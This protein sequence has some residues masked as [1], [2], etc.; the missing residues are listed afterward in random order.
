MNVG[1]RQAFSEKQR[2]YM[3]IIDPENTSITQVRSEFLA[4][5]CVTYVESEKRQ[6]YVDAMSEILRIRLQTL[7]SEQQDSLPLAIS[8]ITAEKANGRIKK[9]VAAPNSVFV[10]QILGWKGPN[11]HYSSE[12]NASTPAS[13]SQLAKEN[14]LFREVIEASTDR[15]AVIS[16]I[17]P[18]PHVPFIKKDGLIR[19]N[20]V[21]KLSLAL[22]NTDFFPVEVKAGDPVF[23]V[24][25]EDPKLSK[26][27]QSLR[28]LGGQSL[29]AATA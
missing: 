21:D 14:N 20:E 7:I 18:E 6:D 16:N 8:G 3:H 17:V 4:A 26:V 23:L 19:K 13:L 12:G 24:T 1:M 15:N 2:R 25:H 27:F 29:R 5:H 11:M 10:G 22:G 28:A 9:G